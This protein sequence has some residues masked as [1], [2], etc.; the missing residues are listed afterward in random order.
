MVFCGAIENTEIRFCYRALCQ[1]RIK[2][3]HSRS[4]NDAHCQDA[5][6]DAKA[7]IY[8]EDVPLV[9]PLSRQRGGQIWNWSP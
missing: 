6:E 5:G 9:P 7:S 2:R 1:P 8:A 4:V 3:L